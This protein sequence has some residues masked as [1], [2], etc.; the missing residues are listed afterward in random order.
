MYN[1]YTYL[2][3]NVVVSDRYT[4][5]NLVYYK[6]NGDDESYDYKICV[7]IFSTILFEVFLILR[8]SEQHMI[9]NVYWSSYRVPPILVRI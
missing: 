9:R 6:H 2:Y 3:H 4:N 1:L 7:L 5:S 8:R